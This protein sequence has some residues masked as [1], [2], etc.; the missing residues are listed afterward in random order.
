MGATHGLDMSTVAAH[1]CTHCG[2]PIPLGISTG[3]CCHGCE[4][5]FQWIEGHR[6]GKYYDL[7]NK[8][9]SVRRSQPVGTL[10]SDYKQFDYL[11]QP[12]ALEQ[13][14]WSDQRGKWMEF[15][16]EGVHCIA[17]VWL[18]EKIPQLVNEVNQVRLNLS[19]SIAT[20][21]ISE[22]GKFSKAARELTLMGYRPHPVPRENAA[23]KKQLSDRENRMLL[24]RL[25]VAAACAGNIML[26]AI[27][28][29]GGADGKLG[30]IFQWL[31]FGLYLP[32]IL[33]SAVPFY[34]S[35]W[36]AL[37]NS[38]LSIDIPVVFGILLGSA[39]STINLFRGDDRIYFDSLSSLVFLLLAT[40][41]LLKRTQQKALQASEQSHWLRPAFVKKWSPDLHAYEEVEMTG[42][43]W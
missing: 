2:N 21:C 20:V 13:Y 34:K 6:L 27:S 3:F 18:T 4:T 32:V 8:D 43:A 23:Q 12:E 35:V 24:I 14:S 29:Y 42:S 41:Y 11:D 22:S 39:V 33:F 38:I 25:G 26:L 30:Q 28:L 31:S 1:S 40:R 9:A 37:Q 16:L 7:K 36:A 19:N 10:S 17:C 5:V 15:Y